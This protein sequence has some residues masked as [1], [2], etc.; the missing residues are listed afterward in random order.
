MDSDFFDYENDG[1]VIENPSFM[2]ELCGFANV[3]LVNIDGYGAA[4]CTNCG[5]KYYSKHE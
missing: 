1:E 3:V 5:A 2:C 4:K